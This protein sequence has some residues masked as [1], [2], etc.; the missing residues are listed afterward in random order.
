MSVPVTPAPSWFWRWGA[1]V[2]AS[3]ALLAGLCK[4]WL[5]GSNAAGRAGEVAVSAA[6]FSATLLWCWTVGRQRRAGRWPASPSVDTAHPTYATLA[7]VVASVALVLAATRLDGPITYD[8]QRTFIHYGLASLGEIASTYDDPNNHVLHSLAVGVARRAGGWSLPVLRL[9]AFVS[10]CL[11]L[12]AVW[13]FARKE[14]GPTAAAFATTFVGLSPLVVEY[15]AQAR[16][17]TLLLLCFMAT[18]LC[19]RA[20]ARKPDRNGLWAAWAVAIALGFYTMPVMAFPALTAAIW[21]LLVRWREGGRAAVQPFAVKMAAWSGAAAAG[22]ALGYAPIVAAEGVQGVRETLAVHGK[23][24]LS[25]SLSLLRYPFELWYDWHFKFPAGAKGVLFALVVVG[26]A[27]PGRDSR[28]Q[29]GIL[30][31]AAG[32]ATGLLLAVRPFLPTT[33]LTLWMLPLVMTAAGVGAAFVLEQAVAWAGTRWPKVAAEAGRRATA[34]GATALV[35][36][37]LASWSAQPGLSMPMPVHESHLRSMVS[38]ATPRIE[39]GDHFTTFNSRVNSAVT[40]MRAHYYQV[41]NNAGS[42]FPLGQGQPDGRWSVHQAFRAGHDSELEAPGK[43]DGRL[44]VF[45]P[46]EASDTL[47][48]FAKEFV[49]AHPPDQEL[50]AAFDGGMVY[51]LNDWVKHP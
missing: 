12:P 32:L 24:V 29:A 18:L 16:G 48:S 36:G 5:S 6:A 51:V 38:S 21:M 4:L 34:W 10:F 7:T 45:Y 46:R 33:R 23:F 37:A 9:P 13:W 11:L 14:F 43:A 15:A 49:E 22:T 41:D 25:T 27:A 50:V 20:L 31:L 44:F 3:G 26:T 47:P 42:W 30:L 35:A 19:G 17:Y 2:A 1:P 8:E 39:S 28:P 40:E